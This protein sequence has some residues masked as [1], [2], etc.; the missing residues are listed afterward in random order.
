[1]ERPTNVILIPEQ[2]FNMAP[3]MNILTVPC[4]ITEEQFAE[5]YAE[6]ASV[7]PL[8]LI[9]TLRRVQGVPVGGG[10]KV[11]TNYCLARVLRLCAHLDENNVVE[12]SGYGGVDLMGCPLDKYRFVVFMIE[13]IK[14][15]AGVLTGRH[16]EVVLIDTELGTIEFFEPNG[17][18]APWYPLV[19]DWLQR[20]FAQQAATKTFEFIDMDRFC[21]ALGPQAIAQQPICGAFSLLFLI[22]RI[23]NPQ[24][25]SKRIMDLLLWIPP[26]YLRKL[27]R[28]FICFIHRFVEQEH[29][30][31]LQE[32][33]EAVSEHFDDPSML[34][35]IDR[36]YLD[37]NTPELLLW[38]AYLKKKMV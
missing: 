26:K 25:T 24:T 28:M 6:I 35:I 15:R 36:I 1:M 34:R 7:I 10:P 19:A 3:V 29:L 23:S 37:F 20:Q 9:A 27:M 30:K 21:P 13:L 14:I 33:Y 2:L 4:D 12:C 31:D 8:L 5:K 18:A 22:L 16:S 11:A 38:R 32:A 17:P